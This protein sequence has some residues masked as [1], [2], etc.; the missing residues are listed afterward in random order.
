MLQELPLLYSV[1]STGMI[2]GVEVEGPGNL[3]NQLLVH[4]VCMEAVLP[5]VEVV[6]DPEVL[7]YILDLEVLMVLQDSQQLGEGN[8]SSLV[9]LLS[10]SQTK[11]C[12]RC[13]FVLRFR[14]TS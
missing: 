12:W 3:D 11:A 10:S 7:C 2:Q 6:Y 14:H 4:K 8:L 13:I 9:C 5:V 1:G